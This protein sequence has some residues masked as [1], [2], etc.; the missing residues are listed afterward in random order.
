MKMRSGQSVAAIVVLG[1]V[2][3]LAATAAAGAPVMEWEVSRDLSNDSDGGLMVTPD[4]FGGVYTIG[5]TPLFVGGED[6]VVIRYDAVGAEQWSIV[7]NGG[8]PSSYDVAHGAAVDASGDLYVT[9]ETAALGGGVTTEWVTFKLSGED[10]SLEWERRFHGTG[11]FGFAVPRDLAIGPDG[12]IAVAGWARTD[13]A[14]VD[15]GVA[16]YS[17]DGDELWT[18]LASS[19]GFEADSA[20]AVAIGPDGGVAVAGVYVESGQ[21]VISVVKYGAS[22]D[23]E[24]S[25]TFSASTFQTLGDG[26]RSVTIDDSG[27]VYVAADGVD[28]EVDGRDVVLLKY[29]A[30][31]E[32]RWDRRFIAQTS[33]FA[34]VVR[35]GPEGNIYV[36]GPSN[37]GHRVVA[38]NA[39]GAQLWTMTHSGALTSEMY[40]DH[41][42]IDASGN[43]AVLLRTVFTPGITAFTIVRYAPDG[44]IVDQTTADPEGVTRFPL[45]LAADALGNLFATGFWSPSGHRD[46]L[47][48]RWSLDD[49]APGDLDGD[50]AVGSADLAILLGAWGACP[51][52]GA[53]LDGDAAVTAADLAMVLGAWGG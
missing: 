11:T 49:A 5:A 15:F 44:S 34:A 14:W 3:A 47:T 24:W 45:G 35:R 13:E 27:N 2:G 8:T 28:N 19:A 33:D 9:A 18:R 22:G 51:G 17:A 12:R 50:G 25:D 26:C 4:G 52:C 7:Y 41:M 32:L 21:E 6:L 29:S 23:L 37:G 10:G 40:P 48:Y 36:S 38:Y 30:A 20:E 39:D 43:V 1:L 42:A 53:D 31:G 46:I 16:V